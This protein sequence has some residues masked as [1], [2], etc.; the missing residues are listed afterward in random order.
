M[1]SFYLYLYCQILVIVFVLT[2]VH[3]ILYET[4][5]QIF[6]VESV[7]ALRNQLILPSDG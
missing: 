4:A 7:D 2:R 6:H 1:H 3:R 5:H